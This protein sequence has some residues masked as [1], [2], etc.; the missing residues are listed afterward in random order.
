MKRKHLTSTINDYKEVHGISMAFR[1][2]FAWRF[3]SQIK[4]N[5]AETSQDTSLLSKTMA[6]G[7]VTTFVKTRAIISK[8]PEI[9][10]QLL[11][12]GEGIEF[13]FL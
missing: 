11:E 5:A 4:Y 7:P 6:D 10:N 2:E 9:S 12:E 3:R 8:V 1:I 13:F